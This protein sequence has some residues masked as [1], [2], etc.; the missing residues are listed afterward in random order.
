MTWN[1]G[2]LRVPV[3]ALGYSPVLCL[4]YF[5]LIHIFVQFI[6][7]IGP[8]EIFRPLYNQVPSTRFFVWT[9]QITDWLTLIWVC[10]GRCWQPRRQA[11]P[12]PC[13]ACARART[14]GLHSA[15]WWGKSGRSNRRKTC[16]TWHNFWPATSNGNVLLKLF[17]TN[18]G[19][20]FYILMQ[21]CAFRP[22]TSKKH[23]DMYIIHTIMKSGLC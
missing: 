12:A 10:C 2:V 19:Q 7:S 23:E 6:F 5:R 4:F 13:T 18:F 15:L 21:F 11:G 20:S 9:H 3:T 8:F 14:L 17:T 16:T 22:T 1:E